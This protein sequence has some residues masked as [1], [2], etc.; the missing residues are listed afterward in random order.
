[1]R[2]ILLSFLHLFAVALPSKNAAVSACAACMI[3]GTPS[4]AGGLPPMS[5]PKPRSMPAADV[6]T[7]GDEGCF[8]GTFFVESSS[9]IVNFE[10]E[11]KG[12]EDINPENEEVVEVCD[13]EEANV[14]AA[15]M[16]FT[17]GVYK[18]LISPLLPPACRF[19]P[20]CSQYGVQA[21][22]EYGE[23]RGVILTAWRI[24]RCSP[25][26]GKGYD[27]PRWPPVKYT[28]GRDN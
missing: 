8:L 19:L 22:Q 3:R 16:I 24:L 9:S 6:V 20:T 2:S 21:I 25:F 26:G 5:P 18:N 12:E 10:S 23:I 1:M 13:E 7:G 28:Y 14:L 15:S 4:F 27:P 11:V 17:I